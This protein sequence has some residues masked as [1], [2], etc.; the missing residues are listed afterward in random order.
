MYVIL[1]PSAQLSQ[2]I[3]RLTHKS[4]RKHHMV[5]TVINAQTQ[6]YVF[7]GEDEC[8]HRTFYIEFRLYFFALMF[9]RF[10]H[11]LKALSFSS[12]SSQLYRFLFFSSSFVYCI[13]RISIRWPD[14]LVIFFFS[15]SVVVSVFCNIEARTS[16]RQTS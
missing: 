1:C 5:F 6:I 15:F 14:N 13:R 3:L 2:T 7:E 9:M 4:P 12:F 16:D 11:F 10:C 8:C